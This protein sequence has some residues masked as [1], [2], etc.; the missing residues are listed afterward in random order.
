[1]AFEPIPLI[2]ATYLSLIVDVLNEYDWNDKMCLQQFNLPT[3]LSNKHDSYVPLNAAFS[4]MHWEACNTGIEDFGLRAGERL[5]VSDF[6]TELRSA[7]KYT[8]S[9]EAALQTFCRL[10]ER[11][12]SRVRYLIVKKQDEVR[13]SSSLD[14]LTTPEAE[15]CN[16]WLQ[17]MS[18]LTIIR[19]YASDVWTPTTITS[20]WSKFRPI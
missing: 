7:L 10:A 8:F 16:E 5:K 12:Q 19:H 15:R 20:L 11:E 2:R 1:M 3:A 9:L 13:I 18:L 17:I 4:L 14:T 6:N